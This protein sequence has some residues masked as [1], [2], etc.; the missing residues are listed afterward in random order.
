[1]LSYSAYKVIHLLGVL[2]VFMSLGGVILH[3]VNKGTRNHAWRRQ[4][5]A[6]HGIGMLLSGVAGFGLL[7]RL[8]LA[9]SIPGWALGKLGIWLVM[10][11][12]MGIALRRPGAARPLWW[13][14][15]ALGFLAAWLAV[16]HAGQTSFGSA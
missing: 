10:G 7:A 12:A 16:T 15:L 9:G 2:M 6:T 14:V 3:S 1:M 13:T 11:G 5:A 4:A 8:G